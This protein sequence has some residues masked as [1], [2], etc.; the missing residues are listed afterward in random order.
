MGRRPGE[1]GGVR[2]AEAAT[3]GHPGGRRE[4]RRRRPRRGDVRGP[5][6]RARGRPP[7]G[8]LGHPEGAAGPH[9]PAAPPPRDGDG[10]LAH[11]RRPPRAR[12][13]L[14]DP[15]R[16]R[17]DDRRRVPVIEEIHPAQRPESRAP[18]AP[19]RLG[20]HRPGAPASGFP[21]RALRN[22]R[23]RH[24][25]GLEGPRPAEPARRRARRL[26]SRRAPPAPR[27]GAPERA[28]LVGLRPRGPRPRPRRESD[29]GRARKRRPG[30]EHPPLRPARHGE[31]RV[32]QGPRRAARRVAL[33][34]RRI[35]R[36][37]RRAGTRRTPPGA[38]AR[39][40]PA[41]RKPRLA[42]P[43]RRDGGPS[44][45]PVPRVGALRSV[46]AAQRN[47]GS[48]VFMHR[49]LETARPRPC[50]P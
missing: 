16:H 34:R 35:G 41:R 27:R 46:L 43:L 23:H 39:P 40:A 19:W 38:T 45:R 36:R 49:L 18:R 31:D 30:R 29:Q 42:P 17:V 15:A 4:A 2:E 6:A 25:R 1:P 44:L 26:R 7:R 5:V 33:Q 47:T 3:I 37:G 50:G 24:R 48:K 10:P 8:V 22:R 11:G 14:P 13:S 28:R 20:E 32:L 9:R 21:A 12:P